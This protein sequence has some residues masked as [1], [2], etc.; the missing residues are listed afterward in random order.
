MR[1]QEA[2]ASEHEQIEPAEPLL[3]LQN[4]EAD[5]DEQSPVAEL[6]RIIERA[7][8]PAA[9]RRQDEHSSDLQDDCDPQADLEG[10]DGA[11]PELPDQ[12]HDDDQR[13]R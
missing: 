11:L 4:Q 2:G 5:S 8:R 3:A 10:G 1:D 9:W 6:V 12:A 13:Q 7:D